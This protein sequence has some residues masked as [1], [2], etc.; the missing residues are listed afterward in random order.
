MAMPLDCEA[1]QVIK[2]S[3][4]HVVR[5]PCIKPV[6]RLFE[7]ILAVQIYQTLAKL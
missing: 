3:Q 2:G 1:F 6:E 7:G 4:M 5:I